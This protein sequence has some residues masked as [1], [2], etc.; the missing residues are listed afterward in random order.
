MEINIVTFETAKLLKEFGFDVMCP[1]CYGVSILGYSNYSFVTNTWI[2][3]VN[4]T[5]K[6]IWKVTEWTDIK[7]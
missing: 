1:K 5:E 6:G 2:N 7:I 4:A 3:C